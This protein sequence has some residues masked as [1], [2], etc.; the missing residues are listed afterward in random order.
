MARSAGRPKTG[1]A[2]LSQE[3]ILAETLKL[4]DESGV[5]A[6]TMRR[7]AAVLG[8]DPMAIY[9]HFP[10]KRAVIGGL[11]ETMLK[12]FQFS[13]VERSD[14]R[15]GIRQFA[16]AYREMVRAHANLVLYFVLNNELAAEGA[17]RISEPLYA[18]L[19]KAGLSPVNMLR[20]ADT[21]IDFLN[22]F[23]LGERNTILG[24][25]GE[26][27]SIVQML[28]SYSSDQFP[29]MRRLYAQL[30]EEEMRGDFDSA[31]NILI[32]GIEALATSKE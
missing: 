12:Q 28:Q 21:L 8:V 29:A 15:S 1:K 5:E 32:A 30:S 13:T 2:P 16:H 25:P 31:L 4:I 17:F 19:Q 7:L 11:V 3:R 9:H 26:R 18:I 20:A 22:G 6:F 27:N 24:E 14:W 10:N 23:A